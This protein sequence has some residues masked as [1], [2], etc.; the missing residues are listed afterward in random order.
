[1]VK[2][3]TK[4]EVNDKLGNREFPT[5]VIE[6]FNE[7]IYEAKLKNSS[8]VTQNSVV[9]RII[10]KQ[11][12][13]TRAEVFDNHW[14]DIEAYYTKAGWSVNYYKPPYYDTESKAYFTFE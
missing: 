6:S 5:F 9:D 12:Q 7:L 3:I 13:Y 2:A 11:P 14:L 10:L 4:Q 8:E 1:M